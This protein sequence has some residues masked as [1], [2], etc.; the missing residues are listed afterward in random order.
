[1]IMGRPAGDQRPMSTCERA[2]CLPADVFDGW[3]ARA[4]SEGY[5]LI[6]HTYRNGYRAIENFSEYMA[7]K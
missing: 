5:P 7:T 6:V 1:M 4:R 3:L 2:W